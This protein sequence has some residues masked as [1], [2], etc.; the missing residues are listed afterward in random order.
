MAT[1]VLFNT[2]NNQITFNPVTV[3][4]YRTT[5][6]VNIFTIGDTIPDVSGF[7]FFITN[8]TATTVTVTPTVNVFN[9]G[10]M[11]DVSLSAVTVPANTSQLIPVSDLAVNYVSAILSTSA[12]TTG[13]VTGFG[14]IRYAYK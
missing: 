7:A 11:P 3:H 6:D 4:S 8:L 10:S 9:D 5:G 14:I 1:G 12:V 2:Q 13:Y